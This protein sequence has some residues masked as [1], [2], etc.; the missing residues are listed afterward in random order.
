MEVYSGPEIYLQPMEDPTLEQLN[1]QMRLWYHGKPTLE[2]TLLRTCGPME[3]GTHCGT[4]VDCL[5]LSKSMTE[6]STSHEAQL[7]ELDISM[8]VVFISIQCWSVLQTILDE[9]GIPLVMKVH[10][11]IKFNTEA[12]LT[13]KPIYAQKKP[14]FREHYSEIF[15]LEQ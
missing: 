14:V 9:L 5:N 10:T 8:H 13:P 7:H 3:R 4:E 2:K 1:A 6:M 12:L 11:T 15:Q